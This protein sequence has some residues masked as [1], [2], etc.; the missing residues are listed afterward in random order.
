MAADDLLRIDSSVETAKNSFLACSA[1]RCDFTPGLVAP[2]SVRPNSLITPAYLIAAEELTIPR[3][4]ALC[5]AM[6]LP[7]FSDAVPAMRRRGAA[8]Y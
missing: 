3:H 6:R 2:A 7:H 1:L 8:A 5:P 4:A